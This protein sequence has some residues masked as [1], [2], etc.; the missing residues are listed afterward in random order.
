MKIVVTNDQ[1]LTQE[2]KAR[3]DSLGEV[4]YYDSLPQST[5]E[6]LKRVKGADI[7]CS[8]TAGLREG[9]TGLKDVYVTVGFVSVAFVDLAVLSKNNVKIS[10]AP[11]ANRHAVSEWIMFMIL[12][13]M[14]GF[15]DSLN[16]RETYRKDGGLPPRT[17]GLADR[18]ITILGQG[19]IGK[20][21]AEIAKAFEMNIRFFKRGNDLSAAVKDADVVVDVLSTN[22]TTKGLL[23][24]KF[25]ESMKRGSYFATVTGPEIVDYEAMIK[26]LDSGKLNGAASDCGSALVGDAEDPLYIKLVDHPKMYVTPHISYNSEK[27]RQ[28]GAD[29]MIDNIEAWIKGKPQNL[30]TRVK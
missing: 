11:G 16:R 25:F 28:L 24:A 18:N 26:A 22:P 1:E 9:Y 5:E 2:Q 6:Y 17:S 23:D 12:L 27:A 29:I 8:G 3:L 19:N 21:V 20:R 30:V 4:T 13:M 10:N 15:D 7:I 14:R